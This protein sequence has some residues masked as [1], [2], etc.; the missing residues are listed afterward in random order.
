MDPADY[1]KPWFLRRV[2]ALC[3]AADSGVIVLD[4]TDEAFIKSA[5][6]HS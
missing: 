4:A 6:N 1:I 2:I 5:L 3:T